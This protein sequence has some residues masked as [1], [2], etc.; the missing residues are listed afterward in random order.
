MSVELLQNFLA[1]EEIRDLQEMAKVHRGWT[2]LLKLLRQLHRAALDQLAT[3]K[4]SNDAYE[5]RGYARGIG[6]AL[7]TFQTLYDTREEI[8]DGSPSPTDSAAGSASGPR[9]ADASSD[10]DAGP[11]KS[12]SY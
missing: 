11:P 3:F 7:E 6:L 12:F 9:S 8:T 4:D 1:P 10:I 2:P 5:K